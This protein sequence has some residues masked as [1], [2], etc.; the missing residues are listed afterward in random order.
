MTK[1]NVT[2]LQE[3]TSQPTARLMLAQTI[4][5]CGRFKEVAM[6]LWPNS[7]LENA[8]S[9]LSRALS[10]NDDMKLD[11]DAILP[12][13]EITGRDDF[14][15]WLCEKRGYEM[16]EKKP[17]PTLEIELKELGAFKKNI[18]KQLEIF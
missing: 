7:T 4:H 12:I 2:N 18:M 8:L 16:P 15:R 10:I 3:P 17:A 9:Y 6:A 5:G 11:C 14:I 1:V 13:L